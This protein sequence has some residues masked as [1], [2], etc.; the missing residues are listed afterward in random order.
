MPSPIPPVVLDLATPNPIN[1]VAIAI[2]TTK[3]QT[4][5][6]AAYLREEPASTNCLPRFLH[7]EPLEVDPV[8]A[9][10]LPEPDLTVS[11]SQA[12]PWLVQATHAAGAT[13]KMS[14]RAC[15]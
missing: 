8:S 11:P 4:R 14:G 12:P 9:E 2:I 6:P 13:Q 3:N 15:H 1:T 5:K 7:L 10:L